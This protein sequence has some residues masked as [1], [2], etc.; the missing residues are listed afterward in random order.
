MV[1]GF[2]LGSYLLLIDYTSRLFRAG[3]AA[4][5][6]QVAE[7]LDRPGC[8]AEQWQAWLG[9]LRLGRLLCRY[10]VSLRRACKT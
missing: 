5:S 3:K 6:R 1:E 2:A 10:F 4:L 7:I 8:G 9:K